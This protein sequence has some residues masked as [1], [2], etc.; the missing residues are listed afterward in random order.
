MSKPLVS[1][2]MPL[3]NKANCV[4]RAI[5]SAINQS[6]QN[7]ELIIVDDGSTDNSFDI[8]EK[9]ISSLPDVYLIRQ[10]NRGPGA[11][12][13]VGLSKAKGKYVS[14]LDAD[15]EWL[16]SFL[17]V[18]TDFMQSVGEKCTTVSTCYYLNR[19]GSSTVDF[20]RNNGFDD[21]MIKLTPMSD[22]EFSVR[23]L[24][25][26]SPWNTLAKTSEVKKYGGFFDRYRCLYA[27]DAYLWLKVLMNESVG[28]ILS[29]H[30]IFHTQ[31]SQL[32]HNLKGPHPIAPFLLDPGGIRDSCPSEMM[33]LLDGILEYRAVQNAIHLAKYGD[34]KNGRSLLDIFPPSGVRRSFRYFG[35]FLTIIAFAYPTLRNL[36]HKFRN[37]GIWAGLRM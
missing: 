11:A 30:V 20:W 1:I 24:A 37:N 29:P 7:W 4:Q 22:I 23:L 34:G 19:K 27:E 15:D 2:V 32:S 21:G 35:R 8:A 25:F 12:R 36:K 16:P 26:I 13:N 14:F 28:I 5:L 18:T 31:A 10:Q 9:T 17:E 33:R 3:F 6:F